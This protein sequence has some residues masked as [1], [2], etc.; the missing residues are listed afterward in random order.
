MMLTDGR[1]FRLQSSVTPGSGQ[2]IRFITATEGK[3]RKKGVKDTALEK[4]KQAK[5]QGQQQ[6]ENAMKQL[7]TPGGCIG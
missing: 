6:W 4:T 2:A 7:K 3:E 5:E 1:H